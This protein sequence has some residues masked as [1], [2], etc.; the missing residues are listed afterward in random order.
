MQITITNIEKNKS[1]FIHVELSE[2]KGF[3]LVVASRVDALTPGYEKSA[4]EHE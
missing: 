2:F 3:D 1:E 4:I